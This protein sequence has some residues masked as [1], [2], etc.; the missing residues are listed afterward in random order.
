MKIIEGGSIMSIIPMGGISWSRIMHGSWLAL[1]RDR[2][3]QDTCECMLYTQAREKENQ[4][5]NKRVV[6]LFCDCVVVHL[7]SYVSTA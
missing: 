7:L 4:D 5:L 6:E 1:S 2:D 3:R